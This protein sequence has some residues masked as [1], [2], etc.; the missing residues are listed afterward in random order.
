MTIQTAK[1]IKWK[2]EVIADNSGEWCGNAMRYDTKEEA[3][4]AAADLANRWLLVRDFR[5][6]TD[7]DKSD[8]DYR[9][10]LA[11]QP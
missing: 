8:P 4:A 3:M 11:N 2:I 5:A 9:C 10:T 6:V 7:L 1:D